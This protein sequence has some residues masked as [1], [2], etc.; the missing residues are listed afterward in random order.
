MK[1]RHA[2]A[3]ALVGWYVMVPMVQKG[4]AVV[5][6][7]PPDST[8]AKTSKSKRGRMRYIRFKLAYDP[9]AHL[10]KWMMAYYSDSMRSCQAFLKNLKR[11]GKPP[12]GLD[13]KELAKWK[14][15]NRTLAANAK[16][17]ASDDPR[18]K[19]NKHIRMFQSSTP[20]FRARVFRSLERRLKK[21]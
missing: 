3:L 14:Q 2:V 9:K 15:M 16:C 10:S 1:P 12:R 18:L 19:G 17:I 5:S 8:G 20:Q 4:K 11:P 6:D 21:G 13:E 7:T